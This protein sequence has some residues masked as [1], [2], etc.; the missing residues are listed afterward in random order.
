MRVCICPHTPPFPLRLCCV[1]LLRLL[2]QVLKVQPSPEGVD[3]ASLDLAVAALVQVGTM[4]VMVQMGG[5][6]GCAGAGVYDGC[7]GADGW[8]QRLRWCRWVQ[9]L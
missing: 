1:Q 2:Q 6:S 7:D 8:G 9:W 3:H 5:G 4:A